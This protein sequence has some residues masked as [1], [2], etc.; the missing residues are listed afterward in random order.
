M[1]YLQEALKSGKEPD[2]VLKTWI[3]RFAGEL[4]LEI[5]DCPVQ[6]AA[7]VHTLMGRDPHLQ[8][9]LNGA[10]QPVS[11]RQIHTRQALDAIMSTAQTMRQQQLSQAMQQQQQSQAM[12][13]QSNTGLQSSAGPAS[14]SLQPP[15]PGPLQ[16]SLF[17]QMQEGTASSDQNS[18]QHSMRMMATHMASATMA[19]MLQVLQYRDEVT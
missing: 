2:D 16:V 18:E 6:L 19:P 12:Q 11:E 9:S 1:V 14:S 3:W 5:P 4:L 15:P 17:Q 10:V 13:Q 8:E 7:A